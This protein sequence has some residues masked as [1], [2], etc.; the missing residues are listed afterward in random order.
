[1]NTATDTILERHMHW[2]ASA[3]VVADYM[4]YNRAVGHTDTIFRG[5]DKAKTQ[6]FLV[7]HAQHFARQLEAAHPNA[8]GIVANYDATNL[9]GARLPME[10]DNRAL[11]VMLEELLGTIDQLAAESRRLNGDDTLKPKKKVRK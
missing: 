4:A 10:I 9:V 5:I 3:R 6:V 7:C 2:L 8:I 1:M 11:Q